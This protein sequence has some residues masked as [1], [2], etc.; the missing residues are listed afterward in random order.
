MKAFMIIFF[1][2]I[3]KIFFNFALTLKKLIAV[4]IKSEC[5][6]LNI[7]SFISILKI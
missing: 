5:F 2:E 7:F 3:M 4:N 1:E 6:Y